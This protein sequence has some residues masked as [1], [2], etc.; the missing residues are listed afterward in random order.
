MLQTLQLIRV[1]LGQ[2]FHFIILVHLWSYQ[3]LFCEENVKMCCVVSYSLLRRRGQ[4][5]IKLIV[6]SCRDSQMDMDSDRH[7]T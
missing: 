6:P 2:P 3:F 5:Y 7:H 4:F 1:V